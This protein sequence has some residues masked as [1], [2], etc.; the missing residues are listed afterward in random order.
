VYQTE[1]APASCR[2]SLIAVYTW[3]VNAGAT[4]ASG[5]VFNT[6]MLPGAA[7]YKIV[8]GVQMIFP[9]LLLAA[10]PFI[11]ES[12]R[13]LC[14][15]GR[16]DEALVVLKDL[17]TSDEIAEKELLDVEAALEMRNSDGKWVDL[18]RGTNLRR[19]I[20]AWVIPIIEGWQGLSFMGNYL[21]VFLIS[22]GAT[23]QYFL[24]LMLQLTI[25][26]TST[27]T[28]WAPD[29]LGRRPMLIVGAALMFVSMYVTAGVSG[30]NATGIST[31]R[32]TVAVGF[33]FVWAIAHA[34]TWQTLGYTA[35][36]EIPTTKLRSKTSGMAYFLQQSG[37]L[38]VTFISPYMQN[39]GY[40]NMG[41]Y[42]G[43]FFGSF[44]LLGVIFVYFCYPETKGLSIE[45]LDVLFE[46]K[47]RTWDFKKQARLQG[48]VAE[49]VIDGHAQGG[50]VKEVAEETV[51]QRKESV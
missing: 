20:I 30:Q 4:C 17:R 21:I 14:M 13:Y 32:K 46:Q 8:M 2:G 41:A 10:I 49:I 40:G 5:I 42:I 3:F 27:L 25:F 18:I 48:A 39:P 24:S 26:F 47:T 22:L 29:H 28:F 35:P 16:R 50:D 33:L 6:Y 9:L 51:T 31:D 12:P 1:C 43:F 11:P 38:I 45:R 36:A 19:T 34:G 15:K 44:S 37:G 23:N 7:A